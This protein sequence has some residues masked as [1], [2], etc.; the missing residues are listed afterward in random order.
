[1]AQSTTILTAAEQAEARRIKREL[2]T[3]GDKE[4]RRL[5]H[6]LSDAQV[7]RLKRLVQTTSE[8]VRDEREA[9]RG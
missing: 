7:L 6:E 4:L 8:Q 1:M 9:R 5:D 2:V 3:S